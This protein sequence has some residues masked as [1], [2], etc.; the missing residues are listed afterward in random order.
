MSNLALSGKW[1][2]NDRRPRAANRVQE[3]ATAGS[4]FRTHERLRP[5][6]AVADRASARVAVDDID[7]L[8]EE[9]GDLAFQPA[10]PVALI[11][12]P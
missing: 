2:I 12:I 5:P 7:R 1:D 9:P 10:S 6:P 11:S 4:R 8:R 3:I